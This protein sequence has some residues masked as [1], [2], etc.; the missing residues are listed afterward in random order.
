VS[1]GGAEPAAPAPGRRE[2]TKRQNRAAI[3]G[4]AREVFAGSGYEASSIREV[5]RRTGLAAGTFYNYFPDK[6][7]VLLAVLEDRAQ[8]LRRRLSVARSRARDF[9]G[10]V[11]DSYRVYFGF[12]ADDPPTAELLRRNAG[13][14]RALAGEPELA[15]GIDDLLGDLRATI[16]SGAAPS[17]DAEY[18]TA[19]MAGAGLEIGVRMLARHPPDI[20]GAARFTTALFLGG[21]ERLAV[22]EG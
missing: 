16:A 21:V 9:E 5:I 12:L 1:A 17:F 20:E 8:E 18:M 22:A 19:A 3:L 6:E 15:G 13:A 2:Q 14:V 4:A 11:R 7:S 10:L